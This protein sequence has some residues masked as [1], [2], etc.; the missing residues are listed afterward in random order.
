ML[1]IYYVHP[2]ENDRKYVIEIKEF[3]HENRHITM[4]DLANGVGILSG[5][6]QSIVAEVLYI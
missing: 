4:H 3:V 6:C 5:S 1:S 2:Q